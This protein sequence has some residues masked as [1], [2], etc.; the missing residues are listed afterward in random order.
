MNGISKAKRPITFLAVSSTT[1]PESKNG[2]VSNGSALKKKP[3]QQ[4]ILSLE[5]VVISRGGKLVTKCRQLQ[6]YEEI[7]QLG[8]ESYQ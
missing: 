3:R 5:V 2:G 6:L 1:P 7:V 4:D 8:V